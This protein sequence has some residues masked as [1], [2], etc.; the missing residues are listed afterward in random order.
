[1][2]LIHDNALMEK[3]IHELDIDGKL[4]R[5]KIRVVL[6]RC[7]KGE[8][9]SGPHIRQR[10]LFYLWSGIIQIYG[11]GL[12][13]RKIPVN[14]A[15]K[16]DVIGDV[17]FCHSRNSNLFSEVLKE[18]LCIGIPIREN[19]E[20]LENDVRF[21]RFLLKSVT[22]K[23][24]LTSIAESPPVSVEERLLQYLR[25]E[26]EDNTIDGVEHTA[27]RLRCS[28]RQLQR[29]LAALINRGE[30]EKTGKGKYRLV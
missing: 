5:E 22:K 4:D 10:Y 1:M 24:Y 25:E 26:C 13:G 19:R 9:L 12:D 17:E 3:M 8:L 6:L 18:A 28:R 11:I 15:R 23:V 20:Y 21:L 27:L 30:L 7:E 29:A 2:K 16:G 14:L